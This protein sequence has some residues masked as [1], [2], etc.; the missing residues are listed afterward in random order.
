MI[1]L[2]IPYTLWRN[3]VL[4]ARMAI[5]FRGSSTD[6]FAGLLIPAPEFNDVGALMQSHV[7]IVP[8]SPVFQ[9]RHSAA[10]NSGPVALTPMTEAE[11]R[12]VPM[13][14]QLMVLDES[15]AVVDADFITINPM[16]IPDGSGEFP[17]ACRAAG[18]APGPGWAIAVHFPP[19][20][21]KAELEL[22]RDEL[23]DV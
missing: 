15:G 6:G 13:H 5:P 12:G 1:E 20:P 7:S 2:E 11:A 9:H 17:D 16:E 22:R 10:P 8:G 3:G 19:L 23:D 14:E 18:I 21:G 4:L